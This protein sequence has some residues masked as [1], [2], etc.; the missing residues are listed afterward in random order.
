MIEQMVA[1][2]ATD[3]NIWLDKQCTRTFHSPAAVR[4]SKQQVTFCMIKIAEQLLRSAALLLLFAVSTAPGGF[5]Q[6]IPPASTGQDE[7]AY[8]KTI[9]ERAEK[10]VATL[11]ISDATK[12]IQIREMIAGMRK[13]SFSKCAWKMGSYP[14][15]EGDWLHSLVF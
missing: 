2:E 15:R 13:R 5:G 6:Q 3:R 4:E 12:A 11:G 10:I 9:N 1:R 7:V 14:M 8:T